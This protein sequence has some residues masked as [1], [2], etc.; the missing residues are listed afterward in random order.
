MVL[1]D[2]IQIV[3]PCSVPCINAVVG[4]RLTL[5]ENCCS[6]QVLS[7]LTNLDEEAVK[8][9]WDLRWDANYED[10]K[11]RKALQNGGSGHEEQDSEGHEETLT[12]LCIGRLVICYA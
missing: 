8:A 4:P 7:D 12:G 6:S 3:E 9:G 1:S 10:L 5:H 2:F 11:V